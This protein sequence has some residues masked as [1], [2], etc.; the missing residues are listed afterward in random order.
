MNKKLL[1]TNKGIRK[2]QTAAGGPLLYEDEEIIPND[3][4]WVDVLGR[5]KNPQLEERGV[6]GAKDHRAWEELNPIAAQWGYV[7]GA[8]P[9]LIPAAA[10]SAT[11]LP[12]LVVSAK[13]LNTA[14]KA[15]RVARKTTPFFKRLFA[16]K[17]M[18]NLAR[19]PYKAIGKFGNNLLSGLFFGHGVKRSVEEGGVSPVTALELAAGTGLVK[20]A[21]NVYKDVKGLRKL[22]KAKKAR[23]AR[24]AASEARTTLAPPPAE[25]T[26]NLD[27]LNANEAVRQAATQAAAAPTINPTPVTPAPAVATTPPPTTVVT[28]AAI[29]PEIQRLQQLLTHY[30]TG[31]FSDI[32]YYDDLAK[33]VIDGKL[34]N[35]TD[36]LVNTPYDKLP[37]Y[38]QELYDRLERVFL[39]DTWE[40]NTLQKRLKTAIAEGKSEQEI[41]AIRSRIQ[42]IE[43]RSQNLGEV[44]ILNREE[45]NIEYGGNNMHYSPE[46][47]VDNINITSANFFNPYGRPDVFLSGVWDQLKTGDKISIANG[48]GHL[49]INSLP[50]YLS[51]L[52]RRLNQAMI[53][54]A[55]EKGFLLEALSDRYVTNGL[56]RIPYRRYLINPDYSNPNFGPEMAAKLQKAQQALYDAYNQFNYFKKVGALG[57]S[58]R[59]ALWETASNIEKLPAEAQTKAWKGFFAQHPE[60]EAEVQNNILNHGLIERLPQVQVTPENIGYTTTFEYPGFTVTHLLFGGKLSKKEF[61]KKMNKILK[62][63]GLLKRGGKA[64]VNGVSVL[65]SNPDAY[66]YVKKKVAKAQEGTNTANWKGFG[67]TVLEQ[68]PS[69]VNSVN[70]QKA[71]RQQVK[72]NE[73]ADEVAEAED[74]QNNLKKYYSNYKTYSNYLKQQAAQNGLTINFSDIDTDYFAHQLAWNDTQANSQARKAKTQLKNSKILEEGNKQLTNAIMGGIGK[75]GQAGYNLYASY[76]AN[77][78][79]ADNSSIINDNISNQDPMMAKDPNSGMA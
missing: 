33:A 56:G 39:S 32:Q 40:L 72:T 36:R 57:K 46:G 35:L 20:E 16:T 9:F 50:L 12:E 65:D 2:M 37:R 5:Q 1:F 70:A 79:N 55:K 48:D 62:K 77:K 43:Q 74:F 49:S 59:N 51:S 53:N 15:T 64:F 75:I 11:V 73:V 18:R 63:G 4:V 47:P 41:N 54:P 23:Q 67:K 34:P 14:A 13:A 28:P 58:Y 6:Q 22:F 3:N 10:A 21:N 29:S 69:I 45:F 8:T 68:L 19:V 78:N 27:G 31:N 61:V 71:A 52:T 44:P 7:A 30:D 17:P 42:D 38:E 24:Q 25:I 26:V 66:K 60:I 76:K